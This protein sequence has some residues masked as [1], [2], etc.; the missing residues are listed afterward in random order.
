MALA[1]DPLYGCQVYD[2]SA[3]KNWIYQLPGIPGSLRTAS[4]VLDNGTGTM[5]VVQG[6]FT[7]S[8]TTAVPNTSASVVVGS[9]GGSTPFV[10]AMYNNN[11]TMQLSL[12]PSGG[13]VSV[14]GSLSLSNNTVVNSSGGAFTLPAASAGGALAPLPNYYM[15][16]F[17]SGSLTNGY[18][19]FNAA[20]AGSTPG[21]GVTLAAGNSGTVLTMPAGYYE[22]S[23]MLTGTVSSG[24]TA[25]LSLQ[26]STSAVNLGGLTS[27]ST[28]TGVAAATRTLNF[29]GLIYYTTGSFPLSFAVSTAMTALASGTV[30][31]MQVL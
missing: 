22:V 13:T 31:V 2:S 26:S 11:T 24:C 1:F 29:N 4:N 25:T 7:G 21:R 27:T 14:G 20:N 28:N 5:T 12:N 18:L 6:C 19:S 9:T 16:S 3:N 15:T 23:A 10:Q 30:K 8:S 17:T